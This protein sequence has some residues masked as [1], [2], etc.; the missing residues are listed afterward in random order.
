V[1]HN[2]V[3]LFF[4]DGIRQRV[5][6]KWRILR[7]GFGQIGPIDGNAAG[8]NQLA[9]HGVGGWGY[10]VGFAD[11]FHYARRARDIDLP[12]PVDLEHARAL[13]IDYKGQVNN[14]ERLQLSD[15]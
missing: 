9:H 2:Q 7:H 3:C 8:N 14:R 13:R 15:K 6:Q 11:G 10:A 1:L 12:H 4:V 5:C